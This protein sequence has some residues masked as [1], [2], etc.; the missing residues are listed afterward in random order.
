MQIDT[1]K[2]SDRPD[3]FG[4]YYGYADGDPRQINVRLEPTAH[5]HR[6]TAYVGGDEIGKFPARI[7]AERYIA[8]WM[9]DNP[10]EI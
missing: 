3:G 8:N 9:A 2:L 4:F 7:E 6:W 1:F 5:G 10:P